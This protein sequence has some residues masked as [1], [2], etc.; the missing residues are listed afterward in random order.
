MPVNIVRNE[1][2]V[3]SKL[4]TLAYK[5]AKVPLSE[6]NKKAFISE[7][8]E[9][10]SA[11]YGGFVGFF[12]KNLRL[13][14]INA[15]VNIKN[16]WDLATSAIAAI[17]SQDVI[18]EVRKFEQTGSELNCEIHL[19]KRYF[20][21]KI[22]QLMRDR[23]SSDQTPQEKSK[24]L[25]R[26]VI[27]VILNI[28]GDAY[29]HESVHILQYIINDREKFFG[30]IQKQTAVI[31]KA[32][33]DT[34]LLVLHKLMKTL[35]NVKNAYTMVLADIKYEGEAMYFGRQ[36][37]FS[38]GNTNVQQSDEMATYIER[39][40]DKDVLLTKKLKRHNSNL[41]KFEHEVDK[42]NDKL[43]EAKTLLKKGNVRML[44]WML[45]DIKYVI[46]EMDRSV[47]LL[48]SSNPSDIGTSKKITQE[49]EYDLGVVVMHFLVNFNKHS[50]KL[51]PSKMNELFINGSELK[52]FNKVRTQLKTMIEII[53]RVEKKVY[54]S[55]K[56]FKAGETVFNEQLSSMSN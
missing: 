10:M 14:R 11:E 4:L 45:M 18:D 3:F 39:V 40:L 17:N 51:S 56:I 6:K 55:I 31:L 53:E 38:A 42:L 2:L 35:V 9:T 24:H 7:I 37:L 47:L 25:N 20:M 15:T 49:L 5:K 41:L 36:L 1:K 23:I 28:V 34:E 48:Q 52:K 30:R 33:E 32:V 16:R 46:P 22:L 50:F 26:T 54:D 27:E 19:N 44:K 29:F 43:S 12:E 13:H 21:A 8:T